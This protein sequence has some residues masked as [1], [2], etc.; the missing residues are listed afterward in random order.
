[1]NAPVIALAV[2]KAVLQQVQPQ[3]VEPPLVVAATIA[4]IL[5]HPTDLFSDEESSDFSY[6]TN[7]YR[8]PVPVEL[9]AVDAWL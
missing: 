8:P 5:P 1:M 2:A 3:F 6:G 4:A 7:S 9:P